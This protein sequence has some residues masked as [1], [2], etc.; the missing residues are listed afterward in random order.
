MW[1]IE[2]KDDLSLFVM[3]ELYN[4]LKAKGA[5]YSAVSPAID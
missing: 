1:T 3:E 5:F 4:S 2:F